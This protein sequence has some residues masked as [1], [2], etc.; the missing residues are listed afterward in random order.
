M[1]IRKHRSFS[2]LPAGFPAPRTCLKGEAIER[3][4]E[5]RRNIKPS[6]AE[7][8]GRR[9][10]RAAI[11]QKGAAAC[12][13]PR[14]YAEQR[15]CDLA[16]VISQISSSAYRVE[17]HLPQLVVSK[18]FRK[19]LE[20]AASKVFEASAN[21]REGSGIGGDC[22]GYHDL[23]D[24]SRPRATSPHQVLRTRYRPHARRAGIDQVLATRAPPA[25]VRSSC[26]PLSTRTSANGARAAPA[27]TRYLPPASCWPRAR[28][29]G[30][31][32]LLPIGLLPV[33]TSKQGLAIRMRSGECCVQKADKNPAVDRKKPGSDA[34]TPRFYA[35]RACSLKPHVSRPG[36]RRCNA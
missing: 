16:T 25:P 24:T 3:G 17:Q 36:A 33:R 31:G 10:A 34:E 29:A 22:A 20:G 35:V 15:V 4:V 5:A 2:S 28:A 21:L 8:K 30:V 13:E 27:S 18:A 9:N 6:N 1:F 32:H 7:S 12:G 23:V 11:A 19:G 14:R 26:W